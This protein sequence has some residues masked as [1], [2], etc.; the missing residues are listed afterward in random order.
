MFAAA[1]LFWRHLLELQDPVGF[2][3]GMAAAGDS[4]LQLFLGFLFLIPTAFL[5]RIMAKA[6]AVYTA[7]SKFLFGLSL[8][9]PVCM[10]VVLLGDHVPQSLGWICEW[11]MLESPIVLVAMGI[12]RF[13]A[14]FNRAKRLISY[15]LL[16]EGLTLGLPVA[17][18]IVALFIRR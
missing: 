2:S 18:F 14:R 15:A 5:I 13:A 10:T 9:A 7:F 4:M 3:G 11:R 8:S 16:V 6:E 17:V 1:S 12:S